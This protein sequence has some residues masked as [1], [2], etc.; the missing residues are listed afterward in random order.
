[1]KP[2]CRGANSERQ[3]KA[4]V[5]TALF[6]ILEAHYPLLR[7]RTLE[8][9]PALRRNSAFL[10]LCAWL[11]DQKLTDTA[12]WISSLY[13]NLL[14]RDIRKNRAL[15]FTPP[16][17]SERL[18]T[19]LR[20]AGANLSQSRIVDPAC[21]GAAFLTPVAI[22][23]K[24]QLRK[25]GVGAKAVLRHLQN[26]LAGFELDPALC[27]LSAYFLKMA[28]YEEIV[29][30]GHE[31]KFKITHGN[32]LDRY[33]SHT[34][35]FDVVIS[36]PPY[37]KVPAKCLNQISQTFAHLIDGQPNLYGLFMGISLDLLKPGGRVALLTPTSFLS[38]RYFRKLRQHLCQ[39][40]TVKQ[41]DLVDDR[42]GIFIDASQET[43]ITTLTKVKTSRQSPSVFVSKRDGDFQLLGINALSMDGSAWVLPRSTMDVDLPALF[44]KPRHTLSS[45]GVTVRIGGY[46]WHRDEREAL[47]AAH[48]KKLQTSHFP[49]I[50]SRHIRQDGRFIFS[51]A[52]PGNHEYCFVD[53]GSPDSPL[54]VKAPSVALQR[55]SS[56]EQPHRFVCAPIRRSFV[57]RYGG[58][59]GE[60][61]VTFLI[62]KTD[63]PLSVE[64]LAAILRTNIMDRLFRCVSGSV[65]IS[66]AELKRLPMPDPTIVASALAEGED[67]EGAAKRGLG[68]TR[69]R[70]WGAAQ[71]EALVARSA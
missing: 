53:S 40:A 29:E 14:P 5:E 44:T 55:T 35:K 70:K 43:V 57:E 11:G 3:A 34:R 7:R 2:L 56:I 46:V 13:A 32:T 42:N 4:L 41:I 36:N 59:A 39:N 24:R 1:M 9:R 31:P 54:L 52:G 65:A 8:Q 50:W 22:E 68:L 23:V 62:P 45:L 71:H 27:R 6:V 12:F 67:I 61:H 25:K 20:H 48:Q 49:L 28:L 17:L 66:A 47:K 10:A 63:S 51:A 15:Y 26:N 69:Q 30:A 18:I 33:K 60:N 58:Y 19:N 38:G 64:L 21:G 37:R 16:A